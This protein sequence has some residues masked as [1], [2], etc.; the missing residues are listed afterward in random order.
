MAMRW[1]RVSKGI[2]KRGHK[3]SPISV[4]ELPGAVKTL[5]EHTLPFNT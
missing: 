2:Q 5:L 1:K 3:S 4:I